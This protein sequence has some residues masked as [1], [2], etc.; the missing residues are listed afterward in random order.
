MLVLTAFF[1][2]SS[3]DAWTGYFKSLKVRN[4]PANSPIRLQLTPQTNWVEEPVRRMIW[5]RFIDP[6]RWFDGTPKDRRLRWEY[7]PE[8]P[9]R[10]V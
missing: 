8:S 3:L 5:L 1:A 10:L 9:D 7:W 6:L 4:L 2:A